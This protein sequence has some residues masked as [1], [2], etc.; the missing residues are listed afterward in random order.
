MAKHIQKLGID[1]ALI[2]GDPHI[3]NK[4]AV[5]HGI[6]S[7][8][9]KKELNFYSFATKYCNWHNLEQYAIYDSFVEK[10]LLAYK[11]Q[12]NFTEF[13]KDGLRDFMTFKR[14]IQDFMCFYDLSS[15]N[16]KEIDKFLWIYGKEMFPSKYSKDNNQ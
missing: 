7:S 10:I 12:D 2:S 3:V 16:L 1:D 6:H 13:T 5:G 4:I 11:K 9:T 14:V 15:H 8:K